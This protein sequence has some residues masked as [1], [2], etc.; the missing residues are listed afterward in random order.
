MV[1]DF[2]TF[3]AEKEIDVSEEKLE[4]ILKGANSFA[5]AQ[6][7][8]ENYGYDSVVVSIP[9]LPKAYSGENNYQIVQMVKPCSGMVFE[10]LHKGGDSEVY[11]YLPQ[12]KVSKAKCC[13]KHKH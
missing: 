12:D 2:G 9:N 13:G 3:F 7:K 11:I 4:I 10:G 1:V 8:L 6:R 5:R